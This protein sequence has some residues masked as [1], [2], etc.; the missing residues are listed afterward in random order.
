MFEI[1]GQFEVRLDGKGRLPLPSRIREPL[2][3]DGRLVVT[4]WDGGLQGF[5]LDRWRRI[6]AGFASVAPWDARNRDF[7]LA[8]VAGAAEVQ[9]DGQ[10]RIL[11][12]PLLRRRAKLDG[13][14]V[15]LSYLGLIEIWNPDAWI[16]RQ[17]RAH[18]RLES[19]G[20]P[21]DLIAW[22]GADA[23]PVPRAAP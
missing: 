10:G 6:E 2:G 7:L 15:V 21:K 12:P 1:R 3:G 22:G 23:V 5:T 11:V 4:F 13:A 17:E 19:E 8:F 16:T 9:P 18:E 20:G 14:C